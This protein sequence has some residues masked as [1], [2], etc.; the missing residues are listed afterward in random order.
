MSWS[1][2]KIADCSLGNELCIFGRSLHSQNE[3]CALKEV[4]VL[5]TSTDPCMLDGKN[6]DLCVSKE[7]RTEHLGC[8]AAIYSE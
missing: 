1:L 3:L 5:L 6:T 4:L 2:A 8:S 7:R